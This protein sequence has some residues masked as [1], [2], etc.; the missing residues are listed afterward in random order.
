[1]AFLRGGLSS[2]LRA[3]ART[4]ASA[5]WRWLSVRVVLL[6]SAI[7]VIPMAALA[8]VDADPRFTFEVAR[9]EGAESC[10]DRETLAIEVGKRMGHPP[11]AARASVADKVMVDIVREGEAYVAT[12]S[13]LGPESG[14]R[15][16]VDTSADCAGLAEALA[17]TLAMV[18]DGHPLLQPGPSRPTVTPPTPSV[19]PPTPAPAP[20]VPP[21]VPPSPPVRRSVWDFGIGVVGASLLGAPTLGYTAEVAWHALPRVSVGAAGMWMPARTIPNGPGTT[22]VSLAAGLASLCWVVLPVDRRVFPALCAH[23]GA[24]ALRGASTGYLDDRSA[25]RLWRAAG[26]TAN[27]GIRLTERWL[28]AL[29][30]GV[31]Y[32]YPGERFTIAGLGTVYQSN[33]VAWLAGIGLRYSMR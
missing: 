27:A 4:V 11:G 28:V 10:P 18:A 16:L 9:G 29:Q 30:G 25:T 26:A 3:V 33:E 17:L 7:V 32:P 23:I 14:S 13:T 6:S 1:V 20:T 22:E 24:G 21:P 12:L 19:P 8:Q 15:R 5:R 2:R 31:L